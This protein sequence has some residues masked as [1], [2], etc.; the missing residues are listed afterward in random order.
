MTETPREAIHRLQKKID[1]IDDQIISKR[2][3]IQNK[4]SQGPIRRLIETQI[5]SLL[6]QREAIQRNILQLKRI[7]VET[8]LSF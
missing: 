8:Q 3:I 5:A 2:Q 1:R 7:V 4:Y 6:D